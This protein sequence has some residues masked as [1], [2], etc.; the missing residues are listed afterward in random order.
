MKEDEKSCHFPHYQFQFHPQQHL[1]Q[2]KIL[3]ISEIFLPKFE[4]Y[5]GSFCFENYV[6]WKVVDPA[7][8]SGQTE[9]EK[10]KKENRQ[11]G[12]GIITKS[13]EYGLKHPWD[14]YDQHNATYYQRKKIIII[15]IP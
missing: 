14:R 1:N 7:A 3:G 6:C 9:T 5:N 12:R 2:I 4:T 15:I 8:I 11:T 10:R 13:C